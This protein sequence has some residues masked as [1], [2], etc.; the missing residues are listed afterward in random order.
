[1]NDDAAPS[2]TGCHSFGTA[3]WP[4]FSNSARGVHRMKKFTFRT[5][6]AKDLAALVALERAVETSLPSRE[7]FAIDD[8]DFYVPIV[9]G[10][11]HI[12]LALLPPVMPSNLYRS[13][14][15]L[16]RVSLLQLHL[17]ES[18]RSNL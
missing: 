12:L 10:A 8:E 1:M 11:G 7:M 5:A 3:A 2:C 16:V 13:S 9:E 15:I 18:L 17:A 6:T 14:H 4:L